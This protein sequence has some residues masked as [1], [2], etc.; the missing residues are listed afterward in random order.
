[1][2]EEK[3]IEFQGLTLNIDYN[4]LHRPLEN[5]MKIK[6]VEKSF[7]LEKERLSKKISSP[8]KKDP[9]FKKKSQNN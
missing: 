6:L 3:K 7:H 4:L 8:K 9:Q 1:M 5:N 2:L